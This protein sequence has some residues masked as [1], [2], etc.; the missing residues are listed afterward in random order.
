MNWDYDSTES[1]LLSSVCERANFYLQRIQ[2]RRVAPL[3]QEFGVPE[4]LA[5]G[6][7]ELGKIVSELDEYGWAGTVANAGPRYFGF[8]NGG[9]LPASLLASWFVS[10]WDQN[11][12]LYAM[13]P[14]A[15][16]LERIALKWVFELLNLPADAAGALVTGA[17]MANFTCLAAARHALL[18]TAGVGRGSRWTF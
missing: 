14:I 4:E 6:P 11:A 1:R 8:V 18:R 13:S 15:S 9:A 16:E 5:N 3:P 12:A 2:K 7:V 10:A 17:T